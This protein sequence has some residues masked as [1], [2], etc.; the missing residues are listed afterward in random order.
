VVARTRPA[1]PAAASAPGRARRLLKAVAYGVG[2][3]IPVAGLAYVVRS[4]FDPVLRFD[5]AMI[6]AGTE[7]TRD[8]PALFRALVI[9][10]ELLQPRWVYIAGTLVCIWV[11]RRHGLTSR[12]LW[13]F[14]TMM[15]CWNIALDIK[16]LV[17]RARPVV[18]DAL[19]HAP[20]YSFPSG[21]AANAAAGAT[22]IVVLVW[23]LLSRRGR[24]AAVAIGAIVA[25][26]TALDR[27]L[28]G[29]H[30][31][32]DVLAGV[33]LGVGMVLASYAGYLGW[34]PKPSETAEPTH[35]PTMEPGKA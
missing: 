32:S 6:V 5:E 22:A 7:L 35:D 16:F 14:V 10:Q 8:H 26:I 18:E 9:W 12:A 15:V 29:V 25:A 17:Q 23:P 28:L 3:A 21:H 11:W 34:N 1:P 4:R 30:Y 33:I 13:A 27:V 31:P 24:V 2:F 20:G 19:T